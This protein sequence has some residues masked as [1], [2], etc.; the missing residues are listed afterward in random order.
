MSSSVKRRKVDTDL[1]SGLSKK[2]KHA[3]KEKKPA[4]PSREATPE[5][6][7]AVEAETEAEAEVEAAEEITKSFKDLVCFITSTCSNCSAEELIV[8]LGHH[9]FL[10][11][12]MYSLGIQSPNPN[13][14]RINTSRSTRSGSDRIGRDWKWK[15]SCFCIAHTTGSPR[16]TASSLRSGSGTNP[17]TGI[18]NL[19]T[20]RNPRILNFRTMRSHSW[21]DGHG[22]T[23][24]RIGQE[25]SY[26]CCDTRT[27]A[28]SSREYKGIFVAITKVPRNG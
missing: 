3:V 22:P 15:D 24:H 2:K 20:I 19:P 7:P 11:R 25:A 9:R 8:F 4:L 21:R 27:I 10:M 14:S 16:Q 5:P 26:Y 17:R 12:R 18:S 28:G 6:A 23:I 1:P 13:S